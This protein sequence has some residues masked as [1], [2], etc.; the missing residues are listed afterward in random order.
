MI[1][2]AGK[3]SCQD[4]LKKCFWIWLCTGV[5]PVSAFALSS[6]LSWSDVQLHRCDLDEGKCYAFCPRTAVDLSTLRKNLFDMR[7][8]PEIGAVKGYYYSHAT[9]Q[10]LREIAS[11]AE[12]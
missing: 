2:N 5:A 4:L 9:D 3:L 7:S 8:E 6:Y 10:K 1:S 12:Q 11:M